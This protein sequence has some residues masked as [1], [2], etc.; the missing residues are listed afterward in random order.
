MIKK[1]L[2]KGL[3]ALIESGSTDESGISELKINDIEPN[4]GQPRKYFD[5]DKLAILSE[6]I[7]QH[8]IVQPIIVK[9]ENE[10]YRIIAGERRW[11]AAR[12]AGL[13]KVPVI[14]KEITNKEVMEIALIENIQR[15]DLNPIEEAEAYDKL[16]KDHNMTQED[17]AHVVGR[18]R[19]AIA[20]IL[21]LLHLGQNI[22]EFLISGSLTS[23]HARALLSIDDTSIQMN[24]ANEVIKNELNVRDTENLVKKYLN[25]NKINKNK[26]VKKNEEYKHIEEKLKE[27]LG[28]KVEIQSRNKKGKIMIEYYSMEELDRIIEMVELI[29]TKKHDF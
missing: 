20:N 7:K 19:S 27:I 24:V 21:R 8:G 2:G 14:I 12:L 26:E 29:D 28:A 5:D 22:K 23:G 9:K 3:G 18:S 17:I 15:E 1:G 16:V 13:T 6:S 10:I 11:R 4:K 25:K